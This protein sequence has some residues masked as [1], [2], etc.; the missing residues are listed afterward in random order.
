MTTR[1]PSSSAPPAIGFL[2]LAC[3]LTTFPPVTG[4][5]YLPALPQLAQDLGGS[6]A[7]AQH[8]LAGYFLGLGLGQLFYGPLADRLGRRPVMLAGAALYLVATLC[9]LL[10]QSM[11][12][13]I[14]LRFVQA[15][16]AC[17]GMVISSAMVRDRLDHQE[18]A[19][20]FSMLLTARSLGPLIAPIAG[21]LI[22]TFFGWR[23]VFGALAIFGGSLLLAVVLAMPETRPE[24]V[25]QRAREESVLRAYA[26]VFGNGRIVG[27]VITNGLNFAAQFAWITAAPFLI[28]EAYGISELWFGW[29]FAAMALALMFSAQIN[30]RALGRHAP[31]RLMLGGALMALAAALALLAAALT[32]WGGLPGI[33]VPL[34]FVIASIG[35]VSTNAMAGALAVDASRTGS[36]SAVVGTS[37]FGFAALVAWATG[38]VGARPEVALAVAILACALGALVWPLLLA[39]RHTG[40]RPG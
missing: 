30:R 24:A 20:A 12:Q 10:A 6:T 25:A 17:A 14:A 9:C 27:Y 35:F 37:Q 31:D 19:R 29:I 39:R 22:A 4:D 13:M 7:Q 32:G 33:L 2:V 16:G 34:F 15:L 36:V 3:A 1:T 26:A 38:L 18:A 28:I 8:T 11:D 40:K 5:I 21:G 23:G